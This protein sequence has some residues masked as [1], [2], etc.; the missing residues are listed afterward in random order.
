MLQQTV[1]ADAYRG[2]RVR[3]TGFVKTKGLDGW[4]GLWMH[5]YSSDRLIT[6]DAHGLRHDS[7][8]SDWTPFAVVLDIPQDAETISFGSELSGAGK[9]WVSDIAFDTVNPS[10]V[11]PTRKPFELD[12]SLYLA[13][14]QNLDFTQQP[15]G[16]N[17]IPGWRGSD[18]PVGSEAFVERKTLYHGKPQV[19]IDGERGPILQLVRA[20]QYRGKRVRFQAHVVVYPDLPLAAM[21]AVP[22]GGQLAIQSVDMG[23]I[24]QGSKPEWRTVSVVA[25]IP[26]WAEGLQF[27]LALQQGGYAW[28]ADTSL[29]VV[30]PATTPLSDGGSSVRFRAD[31]LKLLPLSPEN[32]DFER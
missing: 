10:E 14:T 2:R 26:S 1:R 6:N 30:D 13:Q 11:Q 15:E 4:A 12:K 24:V 32:L 29:E 21:I 7:R 25:D 9:C 3:L 28:V 5:V 31:D 16:K 17:R 18:G 23:G 20:E 19:R 8:D 27:G 22:G